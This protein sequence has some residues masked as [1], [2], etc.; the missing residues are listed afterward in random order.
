MIAATER[1]D[2]VLIVDNEATLARAR[3]LAEEAIELSRGADPRRALTLCQEAVGLLM[4]LGLSETLADVL[5]WQGT[6][7]REMGDLA[8]AQVLYQQ[9]QSV[10]NAIGYEVGRAH[11][12][13]CLGAVAQLRGD[14]ADAT[15]FY[16]R[17][18][19]LAADLGETRLRALTQ[20]NLGI[21]AEDDG[22]TDEATRY[23]REA[24][25]VLSDHS[26]SDGAVIWLLN[27]LGMLYAREGLAHRA[28]TVLD[29]ARTMAIEQGDLDSEGTV[30][31]NRS[32]VYAML[33]EL[34]DAERSAMRAYEVAEQRHDFVRR[35]A[36]LR[37]LAAI[38]RKQGRDLV[39][40]AGLLETALTLIDTG[41]D[42]LLQAEIL[43]D[44]GDTYWEST[45]S[46]RAAACWQR[47]LVVAQRAGLRSI[48]DELTERVRLRVASNANIAGVRL[49]RE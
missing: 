48:A 40:V 25:V 34:A 4:P 31:E 10:A 8:E 18:G 45:E 19:R 15:E 20:Q 26:G 47:G 12:L 1:T 39:L 13:N 38:R 44:L 43:L 46:E 22:R 24:L 30:E 33:G 29:R 41:Q 21:I 16:S 5:R 6:I 9:S 27:N 35:S 11:A 42:A 36:A 14:L 32:R 23:F 2:S 49:A 37:A 28:A 17:A 7:E 3:A